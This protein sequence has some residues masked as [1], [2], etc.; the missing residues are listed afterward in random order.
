MRKNLIRILLGVLAV[1]LIATPLLAAG[2]HFGASFSLGSLIA[3]G[4]V[5]GIGKTDVISTLEASG[6]P[7]VICQNQGGTQAPGQ[8]PPS[9]SAEGSDFL[10]GNSTL[11]KNGK[12]PYSDEASLNN[13]Q[14]LVAPGSQ[15]GCPNDNWTAFV[16]PFVFWNK[17]K[18]TFTDAN[19][20]VELASQNYTC[21]TT[22]ATKTKPAS[23]SCT[24]VP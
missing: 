10:P 15:W 2:I 9:V 19:T 6:I 7:Q 17:A 1:A 11:R 8:N 14:V 16:G 13:N 22:A 3:N 23:V 21:V 20:L 4:Y 18:I 12:A 24:P 5:A